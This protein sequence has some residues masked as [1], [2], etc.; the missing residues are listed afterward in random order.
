MLI[1]W[2]SVSMV[3]KKIK[4]HGFRNLIDA[5]LEF[6][7]DFNFI[8][9]K[10]GAGKT[11]LLEAIFYAGLGSSFRVREEEHMIRVGE[12]F[13]RVE[14]ET[15]N[16]AAA[17][18]YDGHK[19][20]LTLQG[21][22]VR[23]LS[24]FI[25]WLGIVILSIEDIWMIRGGPS[26]RRSFIDWTIA[27]ISAVYLSNLMEYRKILRQ[28]NSMLQNGDENNYEVLRL[29]NEQL[30]KTGNE[31]YRERAAFLPKLKDHMTLFGNE[32][33]LQGLALDYRST[34]PDM[35][36]DMKIL[37]R[38]RSKEMIIGHTLV[39]PHRDDLILSIKDR[40]LR[41]YVS[42][43]EERAG[44]IS[45]KLAEAEILYKETGQR[46]ILILDEVGAE[47]DEDKTEILLKLLKGQIF[48][49]ST[50]L[51]GFSKYSGKKN[52][53]FTVERGDIEVSTEN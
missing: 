50:Q 27:K 18:F 49:A 43:G 36:L 44:V 41:N 11:N 38:I 19:K 28:R 47:L 6:T 40:P 30:I 22:E 53:Y 46:P 26:R 21:N 32:L 48:Y 8:I 37:D 24:N 20:K 34:C 23:R 35:H 16:V 4:Y 3:L 14:A 5:E 10:N 25:G 12:S 42:E 9:G 17:V 33:G 15:E 51:P 39:G 45:M 52:S 29:F 31:I 2:L 7:D 1:I 13:L